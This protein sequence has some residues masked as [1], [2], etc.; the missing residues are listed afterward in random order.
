MKKRS[1]SIKGHRTS[2]SMEDEFWTEFSAIAL[3][4]GQ[5][6]ASLV[7]EIDQTRKIGL[8]SAIRLYILAELKQKAA[9]YNP[10]D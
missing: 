5:S 1:I 7:A 10:I 8:S 3:A 9:L 2:I 4:R 6:I